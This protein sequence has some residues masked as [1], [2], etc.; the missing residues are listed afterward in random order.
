MDS[1]FSSATK[2]NPECR[3]TVGR[4]DKTI[5]CLEWMLIRSVV[6][7]GSDAIAA[8]PRENA[9]ATIDIVFQSHRALPQVFLFIMLIY[10]SESEVE[11]S[12]DVLAAHGNPLPDLD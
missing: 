12:T 4:S 11:P 5:G 7:I 6:E 8:L 1:E 9:S 3:L 2:F 10:C